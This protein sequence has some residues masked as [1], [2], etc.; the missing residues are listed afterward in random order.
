MKL[1]LITIIFIFLKT[2]LSFKI[3][4]VKLNG[5]PIELWDSGEA[6]FEK[7][8]VIFYDKE[9]NAGL[10][11]KF[12]NIIS[13]GMKGLY[14]IHLGVISEIAPFPTLDLFF[15]DDEDNKAH[16]YL[17]MSDMTD[18]DMTLLAVSL[19]RKL[20]NVVFQSFSLKTQSHHSLEIVTATGEVTLHKLYGEVDVTPSYIMFRTESAI[21][22]DRKLKNHPTLIKRFKD[23]AFYEYKFEHLRHG[24]SLMDI[25]D[26]KKLHG[27]KHIILEYIYQ[28]L[29]YKFKLKYCAYHD[30]AFFFAKFKEE[31]FKSDG[32]IENKK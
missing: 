28:G 13:E 22:I 19:S 17:I 21:D 2:V 9:N 25:T 1:Y 30:I 23:K 6:I 24:L 11:L 14:E 20:T 31:F 29:T 12:N 5:K 26:G 18:D 10:K 4:R 15:M 3:L 32:V 7:E 16:L 8:E 27:K